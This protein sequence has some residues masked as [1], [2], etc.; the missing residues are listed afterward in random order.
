MAQDPVLILLYSCHFLI[1]VRLMCALRAHIKLFVF[2]NI[3]SG[4]EK[5][6]ITFS[7]LEKM[8]PKTESLIC[9]LRTHISKVLLIYQFYLLPSKKKKRYLF[10]LCIRLITIIIII[11][12]YYYYY[13]TNLYIL[14]ITHKMSTL[15]YSIENVKDTIFVLW[16]CGIFSIL[17]IAHILF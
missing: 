13:R 6:V 1:W 11:I 4:I 8:F 5:A 9:A 17:S 2:G 14:A 7:I 15:K 3:F 16:R 10:F 12:Y